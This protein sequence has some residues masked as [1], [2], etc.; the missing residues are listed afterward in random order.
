MIWDLIVQF[1]PEGVESIRDLPWGYKQEFIGSASSI[2]RQIREVVPFAD[3]S[4][5]EWGVIHAP[6]ASID[7]NFSKVEE[8]ETFSLHVIGEEMALAI[9]QDMLTRLNLGAIDRETNEI[10]K[11]EVSEEAVKKWHMF[12]DDAVGR[13]GDYG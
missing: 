10:F 7:I 11:P 3:F 4:D 1:I 9:V 8:V 6:N 12:R 13:R 2:S 5:R